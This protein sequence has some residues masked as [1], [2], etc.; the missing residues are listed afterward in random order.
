MK[1]QVR[2]TSS[3][4]IYKSVQTNTQTPTNKGIVESQKVI[5]QKVLL[6]SKVVPG[7]K[8]PDITFH[9]SELKKPSRFLAHNDHFKPASIHAILVVGG[10]NLV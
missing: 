10:R 6:G 9:I 5:H 8:F 1:K 4:I 2:N 3:S 7:L